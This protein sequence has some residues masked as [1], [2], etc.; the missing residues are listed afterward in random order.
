MR[1]LQLGKYYYPTAGGIE[2]VLYEITEGLNKNGVVCDVLCSNTKASYEES[3]FENY[4]VFRTTS[5]GVVNATSITPQLIYKLYKIHK[6]YD[7]IHVHH[8]DPM[9][10]LALFLVKPSTKLVIHWH[11]DIIK[12]KK[13]LR[14]FLPLQNWILNYAKKIIVTSKNYAQNSL[15]LRNYLDKVE[16]IPIG[17]S[18]KNLISDAKGVEDIKNLYKNKKIILSMGRLVKYKGFDSLI[19]SAKYLDDSYIILIGGSGVERK[20]LQNI[21]DKNKLQNRV[22]LLGYLSEE[23]KHN[24]FEA[25]SL[26]ALTSIT[27]AEAFGVVLLEAM[28]FSKPI[29]S[30]N[31][32]ESGMSWVN[33]DNVSGLLVNPKDP[34]QIALAFKKILNDKKLYKEFCNNSFHRYK[35]LFTSKE[36]V[37][38][39]KKLYD[40]T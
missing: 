12:Q 38:S 34:Q 10:F 28:A 17:I 31:L 30:S 36:M 16:V 26:F 7:V 3:H 27:K 20:N 15:H 35:T 5:Y 29:V 33:K 37:L 23:E 24:Y 2:H 1:V 11:A 8:P 40:L 22:K 9:T 39:I 14:F 21:I 4:T 25:S 18:D 19:E 13:A 32:V 6:N